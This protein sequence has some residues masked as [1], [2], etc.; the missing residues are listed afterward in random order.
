MKN[1]SYLCATEMAWSIAL[2]LR[3]DMNKEM[4]MYCVMFKARNKQ[5]KN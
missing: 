2:T 4:I 3:S 1:Q 5:I